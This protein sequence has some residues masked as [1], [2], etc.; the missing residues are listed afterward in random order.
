M[1]YDVCTLATLIRIVYCFFVQIFCAKEGW[2]T[3]NML[4][5]FSSVVADRLLSALKC[6]AN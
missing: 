2:L 1:G 4:A 5:C 6:V 3:G